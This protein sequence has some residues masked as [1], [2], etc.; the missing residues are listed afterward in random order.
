MRCRLNAYP[1]LLADINNHIRVLHEFQSLHGSWI[2]FQEWSIRESLSQFVCICITALCRFDPV[3]QEKIV[4]D[5]YCSVR[6]ADIHVF[7]YYLVC[8]FIL[9]VYSANLQ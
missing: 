7:I 8:F 1:A 3:K 4:V 6:S 2:Y 9:C 5:I